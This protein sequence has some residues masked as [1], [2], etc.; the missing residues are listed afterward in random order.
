MFSDA[1]GKIKKLA[2]ELR[3]EKG[4][5]VN[6]LIQAI[7]TAKKEAESVGINDFT[8]LDKQLAEIKRLCSLN[9]YFDFLKAEQI[10]RKAYKESVE[11]WI[12]IKNSSIGDENT[13]LSELRSKEN[14]VKN[15]TCAGWGL[16]PAIIVG[17]L[18][19]FVINSNPDLYEPRKIGPVEV[20]TITHAGGVSLSG[21]TYYRGSTF[22]VVNKTKESICIC[23]KYGNVE[24]YNREGILENSKL[25]T[26]YVNDYSKTLREVSLFFWVLGFPIIVWI[27]SAIIIKRIKLNEV[28]NQIEKVENNIAEL[29]NDIT[30]LASLKA[31]PVAV[32]AGTATGV[33]TPATEVK[34]GFTV[35]L[36]ES[37]ADKIKVIKEVRAVTGVGLKEAKDLVEGAPKTI[38]EG[39][40]K[41][42]AEKIKQQIESAGAKVELGLNRDIH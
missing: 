35:V 16:I 22:E 41:E 36:K 1:K 8:S 28:R 26:G 23:F 9:S 3:D 19:V 40:S 4:K 24:C 18:A 27:L 6:T 13:S 38:K 34:T 29:K 17:I 2:E 15:K 11:E 37:G 31:A 42:E 20:L 30:K 39:V 7:N 21:N 10:A 33:A 25:D 32:A 12:E 14:E 5:A